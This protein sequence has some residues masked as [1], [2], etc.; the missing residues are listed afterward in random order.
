VI[1]PKE[2]VNEIEEKFDWVC[3]EFETFDDDANDDND[4]DDNGDV[5]EDERERLSA[6]MKLF[7]EN[8]GLIDVDA[9]GCRPS[10]LF[11]QL[12]LAKYKQDKKEKEWWIEYARKKELRLLEEGGE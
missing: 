5:N 8:V 11:Y 12:A 7:F 10:D 4:D 9:K 6:F 1:S 2:L 3:D